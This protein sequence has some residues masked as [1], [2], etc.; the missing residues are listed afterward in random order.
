MTAC[1]LVS[2]YQLFGTTQFLH[3]QSWSQIYPLYYIWLNQ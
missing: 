3:L 1:K 2:A